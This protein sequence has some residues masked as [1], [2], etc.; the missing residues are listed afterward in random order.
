MQRIDWAELDASAR[1]VI[2]AHTGPV[3]A[4][5]SAT[6]GKNSHVAAFL[7]TTDG[8]VFVK[9]LRQDHPG[10]ITQKREAAINPCVL[11]VSPRL[12]W[13]A[14]DVDWHLLGF[15]HT[16]GRHADFAPGS[17]DLPLVLD[18]MRRLGGLPC[19]DLP[20][21]KEAVRRWSAYVEN[22]ADL[23]LLD[24]DTLLHT[25]YNPFNILI[26]GQ[27]ARL[28]DWA[29]PTRGAA[30]IDPA[31]LIV[32]LIFAGHTP[33]EAEPVVAHLPAWSTAPKRA[34]DVYATAVERM[35]TEIYQADPTTWKRQTMTAARAWRNH[36][37]NPDASGAACIGD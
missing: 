10:V 9:G 27:A 26:D 25:D 11:T 20:E 37:Q 3:L 36:R 28:I 24:G 29:W 33:A 18:A 13:E 34:V 17:P 12:L 35:W 4:A 31:S 7:D 5:R 32:R 16:P 19:P 23:A 6:E 8:T 30:F 15:E 2:E 14:Q 21:L 22:P 1:S